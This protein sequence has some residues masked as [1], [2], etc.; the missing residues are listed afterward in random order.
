MTLRYFAYG[1]N[2]HLARF[3]QRVPSARVITTAILPGYR[4]AFHKH[5]ADNSGKCNIIVADAEVHGVV[6]EIATAEKPALDRLEGGYDSHQLVVNSGIGALEVH[7]YVARNE[8][9]NHE[10]LPFQWYKLYVLHGARSHGIDSNYCSVIAAQLSM[11]DPDK[12]RTNKHFL[13]LG[14]NQ[15]N[16]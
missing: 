6:Y 12:E 15:T 7:T 13:I 5:G 8:T 16:M 2:L 14:I 3:K 4:L 11:D 1:S 9:I 10:L